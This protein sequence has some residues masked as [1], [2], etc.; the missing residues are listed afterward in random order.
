VTPP[1]PLEP[2]PQVDAPTAPD[3]DPPEAGGLGELAQDVDLGEVEPITELRTE[4]WRR[5]SSPSMRTTS[6][7]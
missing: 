3:A 1:P 2:E 5:S 6:E 4:E 7:S